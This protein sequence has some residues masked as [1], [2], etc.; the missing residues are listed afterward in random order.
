VIALEVAGVLLAEMHLMVD[1]VRRSLKLA[2][3]GKRDDQTVL[4]E[5]LR[6][7][8]QLY[9]FAHA[10]VEHLSQLNRLPLLPQQERLLDDLLVEYRRILIEAS[11]AFRNELRCEFE[12]GCAGSSADAISLLHARDETEYKLRFFWAAFR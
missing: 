8:D 11:P 1:S 9:A 4:D 12:R 10:T 5:A 3:A 2:Q 6:E 7:S